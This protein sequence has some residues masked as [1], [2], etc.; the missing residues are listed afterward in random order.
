MCQAK[1][2]LSRLAVSR[3]RLAWVRRDFD[4]CPSALTLSR[5]ASMRLIT[6]LGLSSG[7]GALSYRPSA[8]RGDGKCAK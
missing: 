7:S 4:P 2:P 3:S 8:M 1:P 6:L 5:S